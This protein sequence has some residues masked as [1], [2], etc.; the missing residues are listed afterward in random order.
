M[1]GHGGH[2]GHGGHR[3]VQRDVEGTEEHRGCR[4]AQRTWK[5]AGRYNGAHR[6]A[7]RCRVV[8]RGAEGTEGMEGA[9]GCRGHGGYL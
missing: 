4:E 2:K 8:W 5:A 1:E 7:K 3:G 9:E 6:G